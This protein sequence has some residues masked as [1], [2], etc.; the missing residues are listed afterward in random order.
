MIIL[1]VDDSADLR[2]ALHRMLT[3]RGHTV[4]LAMN[5]NEAVALLTRWDPRNGRAVR[6]GTV[7]R[8]RYDGAKA[9]ELADPAV[10]SAGGGPGL[11]RLR[12]TRAPL[13][14][15]DGAHKARAT[16]KPLPRLPIA[17]NAE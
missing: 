14:S 17:Q 4:E 13:S 5:C 7:T 12:V 8:V 11:H 2:A 10:V 16:G 6:G 1:V 3:A 9:T 15:G